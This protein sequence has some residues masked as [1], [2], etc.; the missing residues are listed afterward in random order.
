MNFFF[1]YQFEF[2]FDSAENLNFSSKFF[3]YFSF[4]QSSFL[5]KFAFSYQYIAERWF[6]HLISNSN[7]SLSDFQFSF[8]IIIMEFRHFNRSIFN[9]SICDSFTEKGNVFAIKWLKRLEWKLQIYANEKKIISSDQFFH[10]VDFFFVNEAS[11]WAETDFNV[12]NLFLDSVSIQ[13]SVFFFK[14]LFQKRFFSK[15]IE[16][17]SVSFNS[18]FQNFKQKSNEFLIVYYKR[19][20]CMMQ[21]VNAK[22][23]SIFEIEIFFLWNQSC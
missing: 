6:K 13:N 10:A 4:R 19:I 2:S 1:L 22:N 18:E 15:S 7:F 20:F 17:C 9:F 21:R 3:H 8:L 5:K 23:R 12:M 14:N 11:D 16:S